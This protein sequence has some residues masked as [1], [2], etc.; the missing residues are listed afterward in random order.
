V[1]FSPRGVML[2][3][4]L[5]WVGLVFGMPTVAMAKKKL[6]K[7]TA[8]AS[9]NA[10]TDGKHS[11]GGANHSPVW[12][13]DAGPSPQQPLNGK[14]AATLYSEAAIADWQTTGDG[15]VLALTTNGLLSLF[16]QEAASASKAP[17]W[18]RL[19]SVTEGAAGGALQDPGHYLAMA[20]EGKRAWVLVPSTATLNSSGTAGG[21]LQQINVATGATENTWT[22]PTMGQVFS[23][24][25]GV[26]LVTAKGQVQLLNG[27]PN[28]LQGGVA[29][30]LAGALTTTG[31]PAALWS[32][33]LNS[34]VV[35][36]PLVVGNTVTV[37][38]LAGICQQLDLT[39]GQ[40]LWTYTEGGPYEANPVM[41][42]DGMAIVLPSQVGSVFAL[43]P[44]TGQKVWSHTLPEGTP[45]LASAVVSQT[46]T[47]AIDEEGLIFALDRQTNR[48]VWQQRL[49]G[50]VI[51]PLRMAGNQ[52]IVCKQTG[53][54]LALDDQTG[55]T[56]WQ[57][58]TKGLMVA[59]PLQIKNRL[60][61]A[62]LDG[63]LLI[64]E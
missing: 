50:R 58:Q 1:V 27:L 6:P 46:Q 45:F 47:I 36:K 55:K 28:G 19:L 25:Q 54:V 12:I 15:H 33:S 26:L 40:V 30:A 4:G 61:L 62:T 20:A 22:L 43:N 3:L 39:T 51:S 32:V 42:A 10:H 52:I 24:P 17:L 16:N 44:K 29:S 11:A 49:S 64:I 7:I 57:L 5:C 34:P 8:P 35:S 14:L 18:R 9:E 2:M 63:R 23:T 38:D 60:W 21:Q 48:R 41:S 13:S 59:P 53:E 56:L 37:A 31:Y